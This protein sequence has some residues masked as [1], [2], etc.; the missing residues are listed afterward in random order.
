[1]AKVPYALTIGSLMYTMVSTRTY[2]AHAVGVV[3]RF[4]NNPGK[5]HWEAIKWIF[6]YL[7][8]T[9][10]VGLCYGES[11][12]N[13]QGYVDSDLAGDVDNRKSTTG[14]VYTFGGMTVSW[15]S[16]VQKT[17]ALSTAE[18]EYA[19]VT[20]ASKDMIWLQSFLEDFG[21]KQEN[22]VLYSDSQSAIH[23]A[24]NAAFHSRTKHIQ[25]RY[26]FILS[27]MND[28]ALTLEKIHTSQ[29]VA[30]ILTREKLKSCS[31]SI[32]LIA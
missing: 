12:I 14:Y 24:K 20:E 2:I 11:E 13:L 29:N 28:G 6:R 32:G 17:V 30:D 1:M 18:A 4:M 23:L 22:N 10:D 26:H 19:A 16:Q 9:T 5:E 8:G 21:K 15:V 31:V 3:S 27:V 7:K 25:L